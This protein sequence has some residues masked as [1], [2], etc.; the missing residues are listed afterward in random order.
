VDERYPIGETGSAVVSVIRHER[1]ESG[2][3]QWS[4]TIGLRGGEATISVPGHYP[5]V[6]AARLRSAAARFTRGAR[7]G[8]DEYLDLTALARGAD[9]TLALSSSV[10]SPVRVSLEIP[11]TEL[12][13]LAALL[14]AAQELIETLRQGLGL[15]PDSLPEAMS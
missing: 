15:V 10:R 6:L 14:D 9:E 12:D 13:G 7:L 5:A 8:R 11:R 3:P 2:Y 4:A 1:R